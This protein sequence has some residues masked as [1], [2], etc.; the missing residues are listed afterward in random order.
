MKHHFQTDRRN[1]GRPLKR[2]LNAWDGKESTSGP[3]PWQIY[4]DDDYLE[5]LFSKISENF[6]ALLFRRCC[7][8]DVSC[9]NIVNL[10]R[11]DKTLLE[12]VSMISYV[13][14][15]CAGYLR[16]YA[17]RQTVVL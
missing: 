15:Y 9:Q 3:T 11:P 8:K 14:G 13:T 16:R 12:K 7:C 10:L 17:K 2:L 5:V 1:Y 4:D 6:I